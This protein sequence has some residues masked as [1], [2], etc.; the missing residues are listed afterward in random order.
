MKLCF[1]L[2]FHHEWRGTNRST[3]F[4]K[5]ISDNI[6]FSFCS[7]FWKMYLSK[8]SCQNVLDK[9]ETRS[10]KKKWKFL[11]KMGRLSKKWLL[12]KNLPILSKKD[13]TENFFLIL[14][15]HFFFSEGPFDGEWVLDGETTCQI[16]GRTIIW[17][18]KQECHL[19]SNSAYLFFCNN[20]PKF[21]NNCPSPVRVTPL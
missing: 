2:R 8:K 12:N 21:L 4:E 15:I 19:T 9:R 5:F 18:E 3:Y 16:K 1:I 6:I 7:G 11:P 13:F 20:N 17:Y 10:R 14:L